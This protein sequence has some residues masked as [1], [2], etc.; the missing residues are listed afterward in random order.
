MD[1]D[2]IAG[3]TIAVVQNGQVVLKKGYG[4]ASLKDGR[5]VDPDKTLF[6]IAS[7]SK[8]FTWIALMNEVEAGR[9]RLDTPINLYLPEPKLR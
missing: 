9:M 3:V 6:R 2:H 8:T 4:V 1:R 7:I 5:A